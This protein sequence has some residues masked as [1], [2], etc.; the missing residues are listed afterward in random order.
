MLSCC[1]AYLADGFDG[2]F[3]VVDDFAPR[4]ACDHFARGDPSTADGEHRRDAEPF[5]QLALRDAAG[6]DEAWFSVCVGS[7]DGGEH[8]EAAAGARWE[9]LH[10]FKAPA[11]ANVD[12]G[13]RHDA[14]REGK[15]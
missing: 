3:A 7:L 10:R 8:F 13:R 1:A 6:G 12:V 4:F 5:V 14:G 2:G 9:K 11:Q 15:I